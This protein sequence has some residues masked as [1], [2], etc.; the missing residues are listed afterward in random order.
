MFDRRLDSDAATCGIEIRSA[1]DVH[2]QLELASIVVADVVICPSKALLR[3]S[4][5]S[6]LGST[7]VD[8]KISLRPEGLGIRT[9]ENLTKNETCPQ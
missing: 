8:V 1:L 3:W 4:P 6:G 7:H 2:A 9:M 5:V